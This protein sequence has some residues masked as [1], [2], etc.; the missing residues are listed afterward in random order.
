MIPATSMEGYERTF[1]FDDA[2]VTV[3]ILSIGK[4][5]DNDN[6]VLFQKRGGKIIHVPSGEE[7]HF[8]RMH[9]VYFIIFNVN[10]ALLKPPLVPKP[11]FTRPGTP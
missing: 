1:T 5:T 6:D 7:I 3:P 2:D 4:L 9:G 11:D 10:R 8:K